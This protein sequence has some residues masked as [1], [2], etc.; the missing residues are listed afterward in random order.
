MS[1]VTAPRSGED[2]IRSSGGWIL[3]WPIYKIIVG[4]F[5]TMAPGDNPKERGGESRQ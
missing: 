1:L 2:G 4:R 3:Y 5:Q